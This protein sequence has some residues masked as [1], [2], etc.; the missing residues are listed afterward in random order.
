MPP[1]RHALTLETAAPIAII[2]LTELVRAWVQASG[3]RDGLLTV[4]SPHTTAR[5]TL[6]ERDPA[7]QRDMVAFL[8]RIAPRDQAYEH[9]LDT[10]DDRDNA[11]AHLLGLFLPASVTIPVTGGDLEL[12]GWQSLF[13]V[14]LDGPRRTRTVELHLLV[15][16]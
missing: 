6:N 1:L 5:L 8:E 11:H 13:F 2:D 15:S 12:G 9:N 16:A 3:V 14:E 4:L 7:L 10:V